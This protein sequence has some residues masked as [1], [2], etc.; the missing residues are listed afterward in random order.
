MP[1]P[2]IE[3]DA[4]NRS[5]TSR[6]KDIRVTGFPAISRWRRVPATPS[7]LAV[8][9]CV[10]RRADGLAT[11]NCDCANVAN[12]RIYEDRQRRAGQCAGCTANRAVGHRPRSCPSSIPQLCS[13]SF[14]IFYSPIANSAPSY[15]RCTCLSS[16]EGAGYLY[17]MYSCS[18]TGRS[19]D[20]YAG[21]RGMDHGGEDRGS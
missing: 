19:W 11:A 10:A 5:S 8:C 15:I 21:A 18:D 17:T 7:S 20:G 9:V 12:P 4:E 2:G 13:S 3:H 6:R 16:R 14:P 1:R